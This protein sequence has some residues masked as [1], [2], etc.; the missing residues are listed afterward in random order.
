MYK[1]TKIGAKNLSFI[2]LLTLLF[3]YLFIVCLTLMRLGHTDVR[4]FLPQ[5]SGLL[6]NEIKSRVLSLSICSEK[7]YIG[8]DFR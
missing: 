3:E 4:T 2:S 1:C 8:S 5:Q 7:G 6:S